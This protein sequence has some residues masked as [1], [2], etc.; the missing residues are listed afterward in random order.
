[1]TKEPKKRTWHYV[2]KPASYG[3]QC[4]K[5]DGTN[6]E[7]SEYEHMIWCYDCKIDTEGFDGIFGGPIPWGASQLIGIS[8]DRWNMAEQRVEYARQINGRI[9]YSPEPPSNLEEFI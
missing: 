2:M 1:M 6:I 7:W 4:D 3:V 9:E 8:F 5:C